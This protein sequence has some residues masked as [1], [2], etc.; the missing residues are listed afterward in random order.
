MKRYM[1]IT[2][3]NIF[4]AAAVLSCDADFDTLRVSSCKPENNVTGV[5]PESYIEIA[6]SADV[7][8]TDVEDSFSL[9]N[10]E[11]SVNGNFNWTSH[12][13]FRFIP[14]E[15][16]NRNGRYVIVI[17]RSI[18]DKKGNT[19]ES[20]FISEF[21]IGTDFTPPYVLSSVPVFSSG[22]VTDIPVNQDIIINFSKSMNREVVE[23]EFGIT[24]DV[25]GYFVWSEGRPGIINSTLTYVLTGSMEYGKLYT[26]KVS[27]S[28]EDSSGNTL[29][30]DYAVNFITGNDFTPPDVQNIY[31]WLIPASPWDTESPV[32]N[33]SKG[34]SIGVTFSKAMD[35][36]S[37]E[38]AF[39]VTPT[40]QGIFEWSS[41]S[42]VRFIPSKPLNPET[43]Y[44]LS[45]ETTA[46]DRNLLK[47]ASRYCVEIVTDNP[48]S[49]YVKRGTVNG[50]N[51]DGD[52]AVLTDTWPMIIEMGSGTPVNHN[53]YL[54]IEFISDD[55]PL[56]PAEMD[57]YSIF[58]NV[59]IETYKGT[60]GDVL[61]ASAYIGS[62]EWVGSSAA[63]IK[64]SGMTNKNADPPQI[65]A[66]Y[67]LKIAGGESGIKDTS[68][69]FMKE[70][71]VI[72]F[73]EAIP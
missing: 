57:R 73:R 34:V 7:N 43:K 33:I 23:R 55:E 13:T 59:V 65:P 14:S 20:D 30:K 2:F 51:H 10:S 32:Y 69:N 4:F 36:Q 54:L 67:R 42:I 15:P 50:S 45:I 39:S 29:G 71:L 53:Y 66:L 46:R 21:Y 3:F 61:P 37:V 70:D 58:D 62:I 38:K 8:S 5:S 47:L 12:D 6:F 48:D 19:M 40:V 9:T 26:I 24:P 17:P 52:F 27:S 16:M 22:A 63:K 25:P 44:Q 1:I 11:G 49:L 56:I 35:R 41:D 72:E 18:K 64:I 68:G 28:A 31:D 60:S